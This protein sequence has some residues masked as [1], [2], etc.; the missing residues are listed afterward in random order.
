MN[1]YQNYLSDLLIRSTL[2][3]GTCTPSNA[4]KKENH[5]AVF[6]GETPVLLIGYADDEESTNI[7][8]QLAQQNDLEAVLNTAGFYGALS[9]GTVSGADFKWQDKYEAVSSSKS[10][11]S[12]QG[13]DR[14]ILM[15]VNLTQNKGVTTTL[16]VITQFAQA[17]DP[18]CPTLDNG[19]KLKSLATMCA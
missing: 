13:C 4:M 1:A 14:G 5:V 17:I 11:V 7:A 19:V 18:K 9:V 3:P 2:T 15:T 10:G 12:E 16:C 6:S 8:K